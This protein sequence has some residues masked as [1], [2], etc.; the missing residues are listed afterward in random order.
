MTDQP[1]L[2]IPF[3][4]D[5]KRRAI[6]ADALSDAGRAVYLTDLSEEEGRAVLK[7]AAA[8]FAQRMNQLPDDVGDLLMPNCRLLQFHSAGVDYLPLAHLPENLPIAG[9]GGTPDPKACPPG[10][11]WEYLQ[12]WR[13]PARKCN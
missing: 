9:N 11:G 5:T 1:V 3:E 4:A 6:I 2:A 13:T 10:R 12:R 7:T 8:V